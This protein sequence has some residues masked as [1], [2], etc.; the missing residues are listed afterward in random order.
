LQTKLLRVLQEGEFERLGSSTTVRVNVRVIAATN[1]NL[2]RAMREGEFRPDLYY[3][4][5]VFPIEVPPL[6]EHRA[7]I[8]VLI[9]HFI[10]KHQAHLGK[11][12]Q[13]IADSTM[14]ALIDYDWPG[15][16]RE[17][18]NYVERSL[19]LSKGP[20]FQLVDFVSSPGA[21]DVPTQS[22]TQLQSAKRALYVR[23][24]EQCQWKVKG[25][26]NAA[27]RLGLKPSTLRYQ[28]KKMGISR[29]SRQ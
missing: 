27:E 8:P 2:Q 17:L 13:H 6:R 16:V 5:A 9:W 12:I 28:L 3:R 20:A 10:T 29:P 24:L 25:R 22:V 26:G 11:K 4:L 7:D 18:E 19:I 1:R 21:L 23:T 14:E 15:N